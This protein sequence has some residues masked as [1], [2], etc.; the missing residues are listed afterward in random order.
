MS[1]ESLEWSVKPLYLFY[2]YLY[3]YISINNCFISI[4][5]YLNKSTEGLKE[6]ILRNE[7]RWGKFSNKT[8][9]IEC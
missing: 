7:Q 5:I 4:S 3:Q 8:V 2:I 6:N 1:S 9:H